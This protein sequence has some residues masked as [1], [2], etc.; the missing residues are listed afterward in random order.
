[1][2]VIEILER[3]PLFQRVEGPSFARLVQL[4]RVVRFR[5]GQMIFH[6]GDTCP[7]MYVVGL[8]SVRIFKSGPSGREINLHFVGPGQTFA[9]VAAMAGFPL[10]ASAEALAP[11]TCALLAAEPFRQALRED[12]HLCLGLLQGMAVWVR[13][14]VG[15]IEEI[16][17][18]DALGRLA[19]FLLDLPADPEGKVVLPALRRHVAGRLNLT[20]ET[21]SRCMRRLEEA[22]LIQPF[23]ARCIRVL[24]RRGLDQIAQEALPRV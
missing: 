21:L 17:L 15:L 7:G 24:D 1:M 13:T 9:E 19:R 14:L 8:G 5:K 22:R 10:P 4:A 16:V 11:T 6:E 2:T 12:H 20:S 18:R 23:S 3:A